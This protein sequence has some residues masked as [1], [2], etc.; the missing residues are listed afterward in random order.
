[1]IWLFKCNE[2]FWKNK[3]K[4]N[5]YYLFDE[6]DINF[7]MS[8][9]D[10][11]FYYPTADYYLMNDK[12]PDEIYCLGFTLYQRGIKN[13]PSLVKLSITGNAHTIAMINSFYDRERRNLKLK[14]LG[15]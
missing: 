5:E 1:M 7:D 14:E 3:P 11:S 12:N 8:K 4:V 6:D 2:V 9:Y 13:N 10:I 15:I